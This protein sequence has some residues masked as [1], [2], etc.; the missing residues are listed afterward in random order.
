[1]TSAHSRPRIVEVAFWCWSVAA[2]LLIADGLWLFWAAPVT[3]VRG[4]GAILL[5]TGLAVAIL[6]GRT[7]RGDKRFHRALVALSM[8][9]A[10]LLVLFIVMGGPLL[11]AF[12]AALLI[13][14]GVLTTR[15]KANAWFEAVDSERDSG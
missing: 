8:A 9:L 1:M 5:L 13:A 11:G 12:I 6:A 3:F 15:E 14:G 7:R 4:A 2:V 10:L